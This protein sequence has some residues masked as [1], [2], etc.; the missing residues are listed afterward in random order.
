MKEDCMLNVSK[1]KQYQGILGYA[2][3]YQVFALGK[4]LSDDEIMLRVQLLTLESG[5]QYVGVM[6][7]SNVGVINASLENIVTFD[8]IFLGFRHRDSVAL[9]QEH[10]LTV[11]GR[12]DV[13]SVYLN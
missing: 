6:V 10:I 8:Y 4:V 1:H 12:T 7:F 5:F 13:M 3:S 11:I 9:L 2:S